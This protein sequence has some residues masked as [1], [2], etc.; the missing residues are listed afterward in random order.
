MS[1]PNEGPTTPTPLG[2][3]HPAATPPFFESASVVSALKW[4]AIVGVAYFVLAYLVA[5]L[6]NVI[7]GFGNNPTQNPSL[8]I[9]ACLGLFVIVFALYVAGYLPAMERGQIGPGLL[10]TLVMLAISN[11]LG[12]LI[13]P[14]GK[15]IAGGAGSLTVQIVSFIVSVA[16]AVGIGYLGAFYGVK[17]NART[18]NTK[19]V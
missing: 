12:K 17:R 5:L 13:N 19:T 10:S 18:T 3:D 7:V 4:G 8:V 1:L 11:I 16:L 9:P 2:P 14:A 15:A 6:S